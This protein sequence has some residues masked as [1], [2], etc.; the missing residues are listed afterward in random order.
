MPM[1]FT[2]IANDGVNQ[3]QNEVTLTVIDADLEA[4]VFIST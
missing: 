2:V 4:P 3:T 1:V